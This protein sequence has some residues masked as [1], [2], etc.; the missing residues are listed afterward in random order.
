MPT[1]FDGR[2]GVAGAELTEE[3]RQTVI[4]EALHRGM[5][6]EQAHELA[7]GEDEPSGTVQAKPQAPTV[8]PPKDADAAKTLLLASGPFYRQVAPEERDEVE[9]AKKKHRDA[10]HASGSRRDGKL[11]ATSG[12]GEGK[13]KK[14]TDQLDAV[15]PDPLEEVVGDL[16]PFRLW[17]AQV[18]DPET[19]QTWNVDHDL[20]EGT[21]TVTAESQMSDHIVVTAEIV[22]PSSPGERKNDPTVTVAV[23]DPTTDDVLVEPKTESATVTEDLPRVAIGEVVEAVIEAQ[24]TT[25]E[26]PS[27][28]ARRSQ[29]RHPH[30]P[31]RPTPRLTSRSRLAATAG[32][33]TSSS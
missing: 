31:L 24:Q 19:E 25:D 30:L 7:Y 27:A 23:T 5:T 6:E 8:T 33:G 4:K 15:I 22:A 29:G 11:S 17:M 1:F 12:G 16:L 32:Q 13:D 18:A 21:V 28:E 3:Q 9:K 2:G 10:A 20:E 26:E 14:L